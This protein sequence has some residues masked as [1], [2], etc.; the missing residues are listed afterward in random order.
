ML[1]Y[2]ILPVH[3]TRPRRNEKIC[4]FK[5]KSRGKYKNN[6][7]S[8][9]KKDKGQQKPLI[10]NLQ[11]KATLIDPI[12]CP[13]TPSPVESGLDNNI[14]KLC[15]LNPSVTFVAGDFGEVW[16]GVRSHLT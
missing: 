5:E 14:P 7:V 11:V 2:L 1:R 13:N 8:V 9:W 6:F 12:H 3:G 16:K 15:G 10:K 4:K